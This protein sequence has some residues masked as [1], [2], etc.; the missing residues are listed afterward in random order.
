MLS[1]RQA[2]A[3]WPW[4]EGRGFQALGRLAAVSSSGPRRQHY[5]SAMLLKQWGDT[6][7]GRKTKIAYYDMYRRTTEITR[8][9]DECVALDMTFTDEAE[10]EWGDVE[11]VAEPLLSSVRQQMQETGG[12]IT[13]AIEQRLT[14]PK[15]KAILCRLAA[16]HHG[17][18]M[19]VV[20]ETLMFAQKLCLEHDQTRRYLQ[21]K[22]ARRVAEAEE[23]Y[24]GALQFVGHRESETVIGSL[25][26]YDRQ[27]LAAAGWPDA[28]AEFIIPLSPYL[29]MAALAVPLREDGPDTLPVVHHDRATT[30]LANFGQVGVDGNTKVYFRISNTASAS[31]LISYLSHGG[32]LHWAGLQDRL[33]AYGTDL[34][35]HQ[36]A[37]AQARIDWFFR[38]SQRLKYDGPGDDGIIFPDAFQEEAKRKAWE[39]EQLMQ[40]TPPPEPLSPTL[41]YE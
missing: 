25:P 33:E 6:D 38:T 29:S 15:N 9:E 23:R 4:A 39:T 2:T 18:N 22:I 17:R 26:V 16:L 8:A 27:A 3:R 30:E 41:I 31:E 34:T 20:L 36:R 12:E 13:R 28:P 32:F 21:K 10:Q 37:E 11:A 24:L 19:S 1:T 35:A 7:E 40:G 5:V 14:A